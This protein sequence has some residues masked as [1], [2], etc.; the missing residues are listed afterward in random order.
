MGMTRLCHHTIKV[1]LI[2]TCSLI[3]IT[4]GTTCTARMVRPNALLL[5]AQDEVSEM[6]EEAEVLLLQFHQGP[7]K[8][9]LVQTFSSTTSPSI[10]QMQTSLPHSTPLAVSL[11]LRSTL[12]DTL[13]NPRDLDSS[14]MIPS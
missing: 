13:E 1:P 10:S 4:K 8:A 12:T 14:L 9:Q 2:T 11:A 3:P 5:M 7:V 6:A